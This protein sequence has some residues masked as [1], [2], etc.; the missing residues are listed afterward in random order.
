MK[1]QLNRHRRRHTG[2]GLRV[3]GVDGCRGGWVVALADFSPRSRLEKLSLG[4]Y[5]HFA[6]VLQAA[7]GV[8]ALA[9]DIPI[10]LLDA[11]QP[12]GR[13]CDR[14]ARA[15]LGRRRASVFTPPV[16][17]ALEARSY[18]E[19]QQRNGMG[20][21]RQAFNLLPRIREVDRRM[22]PRLQRWF[23]E[24]HPELAFARLAGHPLR[25]GKKSPSGQRERLRLL[26]RHYGLSPR[27]LRALHTRRLRAQGVALDDILDALALVL[28]AWHAVHGTACR[29]PDS[30]PLMPRDRRGLRMQIL[31]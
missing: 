10:G 30:S 20:L 5:R 22:T 4:C 9:V 28:S 26:A 16:R 27:M 24:A 25:H 21:S 6:A 2:G 19:A 17:A 13:D 3:S 7:C 1:R 31:Y 29:L 15:R 14:L 12:G 23:F 11:P 8:A 18:H